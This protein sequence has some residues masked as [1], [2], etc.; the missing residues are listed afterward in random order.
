[1]EGAYFKKLIDR[2]DEREF[3]KITPGSRK[4]PFERRYRG[5]VLFQRTGVSPTKLLKDFVRFLAEV[6][7]KQGK[8]LN[9]RDVFGRHLK[10]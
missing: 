6:H 9:V 7:L 8:N 4:S 5:S 2:I 3:A 1:M 10:T